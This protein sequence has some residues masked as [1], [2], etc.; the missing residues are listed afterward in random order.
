MLPDLFA[1]DA[2]GPV[3]FAQ[4]T[5]TEGTCKGWQSALPDLLA[6]DALGPLLARLLLATLRWR[7]R[8]HVVVLD[9]LPPARGARE[10]GCCCARAC[11]R[12]CA[13]ITAPRRIVQAM[14]P[15]AERCWQHGC[16]L[17]V[18][19]GTGYMHVY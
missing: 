5:G 15:G 3:Y 9:R 16:V 10:R 7:R 12:T 13:H 19:G 6:A 17:P 4:V 2:L 8:Q 11:Q 18:R 1:A 14:L